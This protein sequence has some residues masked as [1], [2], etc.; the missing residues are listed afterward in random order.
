MSKLSLVFLIIF[1]LI[2]LVPAA[3]AQVQTADLQIVNVWISDGTV[4]RPYAYY[5]AATGG[6][7]PY[8]WSLV[9]PLPSFVSFDNMNAQTGLFWP[10][11]GLVGGDHQLTVKVS[12]AAGRVAQKTFGWAIT[13]PNIQ[14]TAPDRLPHGRTGAGYSYQ[15]AATG[16][17]ALYTWSM[18]AQPVNAYPC[19]T[20]ALY[21]DGRMAS[22]NPLPQIGDYQIG[23]RVTD[24]AG[25]FTQK[26]FNYKVYNRV[27]LPEGMLVQ[28][29][30]SPTVYLVADGVF[31]PF[32]SATAFRARRYEWSAVRVIAADEV[33]AANIGTAVLLPSGSTIKGSSPTVY[34]VTAG[35]K[36][37]IPSLREFY[38]RGLSFKNLVVVDDSELQQ[39]PDVGVAQ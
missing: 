4:G 12:D 6:T 27:S 1:S 22:V 34:V 38:R 30:G 9:A 24:A 16:G 7:T 32:T 18:M 15:F 8:T 11:A 25:A 37:A 23:V 17:T 5:F 2:T 13:S 33:V 3:S 26:V 29:A 14:I 10:K 21:P 36:L 19:C 31:K 28:V 35:K 39:Y 20:I